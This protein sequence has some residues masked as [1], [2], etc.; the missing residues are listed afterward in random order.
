MT[1]KIDSDIANI[2]IE[3]VDGRISLRGDVTCVPEPVGRNIKWQDWN[4]LKKNFNYLENIHIPLPA[5]PIGGEVFPILL[6]NDFADLSRLDFSNG[7]PQ[8]MAEF[9]AKNRP[10]GIKT[11]MGWSVYSVNVLIQ[12]Q[13]L[14][15]HVKEQ[16]KS[17]ERRVSSHLLTT[18]LLKRSVIPS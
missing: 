11:M 9:P 6:G 15:D 5:E 7:K 17:K 8:R 12:E 1:K 10:V 2:A 16:E 14:L 18:S 4:I 13:S 3:T